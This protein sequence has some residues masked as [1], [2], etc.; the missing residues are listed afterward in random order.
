[1][2]NFKITFKDFSHISYRFL[3]EN[4]TIKRISKGE[5]YF[6]TV[7]SNRFPEEDIVK[8]KRL[9]GEYIC[10]TKEDRWFS[11]GGVWVTTNEDVVEDWNNHVV[12]DENTGK[13]YNKARITIHFLDGK[14][15]TLYFDTDEE[16]LETLKEIKKPVY[17]TIS[18]NL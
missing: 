2:E 4:N 7:L 16:M 9:F 15:T 5:T 13:W 1:M 6:T 3:L 8:K 11:G 10:V 14:E 17:K 18:I 12:Y